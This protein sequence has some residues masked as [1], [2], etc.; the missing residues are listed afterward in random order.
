VSLEKLNAHYKVEYWRFVGQEKTATRTSL[1]VMATLEYV[2]RCWWILTGQRS[3][4]LNQ[5]S[6]TFS[7]GASRFRG[8]SWCAAIYLHRQRRLN[9]WLGRFAPAHQLNPNALILFWLTTTN[10]LSKHRSSYNTARGFLNG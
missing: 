3:R 10:V 8:G 1:R 4:H 9:R 5:F 7:V 6:G 2:S